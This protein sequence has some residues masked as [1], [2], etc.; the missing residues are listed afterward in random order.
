MPTM[1]SS[2][3]FRFLHEAPQVQ[4]PVVERLLQS[5]PSLQIKQYMIEQRRCHQL[6]KPSCLLWPLTTGA[7]LF[8]SISVWLENTLPT[9]SAVQHR[10]W[11]EHMMQIIESLCYRERQQ[12]QCMLCRSRSNAGQHTPDIR[13]D[14]RNEALLW[15]FPEFSM[16]PMGMIV[17]ELLVQGGVKSQSPPVLHAQQLHW[18]V[19]QVV[20]CAGCPFH[21]QVVTDTQHRMTASVQE[22]APSSTDRNRLTDALMVDES[23]MLGH[24][25]H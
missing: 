17:L 6:T 13:T 10:L 21:K 22:W 23:L 16:H 20:L 19:S 5:E 2:P 9:F 24:F 14:D 11:L 3:D 8:E 15:H 25:S 12:Q 1:F 4:Q 7:F 18:D